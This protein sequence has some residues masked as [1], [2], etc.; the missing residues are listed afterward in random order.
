MSDLVIDV[1]TTSPR[2]PKTQGRAAA[3]PSRPEDQ[4]AERQRTRQERHE[5]I[6]AAIGIIGGLILFGATVLGAVH[7][8]DAVRHGAER[9]LGPGLLAD[10]FPLLADGIVAGATFRYVCL[11]RR[12]RYVR[13][14]RLLAH[15]G[16]TATVYLNAAVATSLGQV[17]WH[18]VAPAAFSV[19]IELWAKEAIGDFQELTGTLREPVPLW[20]WITDVRLARRAQLQMIRT[21]R[22][23]LADALAE[24][25]RID[26]ALQVLHLALPGDDKQERRT[27]RRLARWIRRGVL[28]TANVLDVAGLNDPELDL[29]SL[30]PAESLLRATFCE[31]LAPARKTT[32][33]A[34]PSQSSRTSVRM[35][36]PI[37]DGGPKSP[38]RKTHATAAERTSGRKSALPPAPADDSPATRTS[39]IRPN[40]YVPPVRDPGLTSAPPTDGV[41]PRFMTD[42]EKTAIRQAWEELADRG[43]AVTA[44]AVQSLAARSVPSV[45]LRTTKSIGN[46]LRAQN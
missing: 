25:H 16:I 41:L 28:P 29:V 15:G 38:P 8:Y 36:V 2:Q 35:D 40:S 37:V 32:S 9:I 3:V 4:T 42:T 19:L 20:M 21:G 13:G 10:T 31:V 6:T 18:V 11:L 45:A 33:R 30:P 24:V 7:S 17:P 5:F 44:P 26:V 14:W 46:Y 23:S 43:E 34:V 39:G 27:R 1:R 22:T 12:G